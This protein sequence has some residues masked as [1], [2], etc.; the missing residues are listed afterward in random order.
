M[1]TLQKQNLHE[2]L[3]NVFSNSEFVTFLKNNFGINDIP[4]QIENYLNYFDKLTNNG[5]GNVKPI[6]NKT[7]AKMIDHTILKP[8]T[9]EDDV[10]KVCKE[11]KE[12][13]TMSV[14][15][16][17][18]NIELVAN[19]LKNSEVKV[20]TV[21]GFPLGANTTETKVFETEDAIKKGANEI[22]MV[23]NI[24]KL[25]SK[26]YKYVYNDLKAVAD[27]ST[28]N[29]ALS[30]VILETCLL[31]NEEKVIACILSVFAGLNFV[32]TSTGFSTA[33]ANAFDIALM[34]TIV[35]DNIGVKASGG[36]RT[37]KDAETMVAFGANRLG[38]SATVKI[39]NNDESGSQGY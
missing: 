32:K 19:Q 20:C 13:N 9:S 27:V 36:V 12:Y 14:C 29:K 1:E 17:P 7:L 34:R 18:I 11:A 24:G 15:V 28:K 37:R 23:L 21:I 22:D 6:E 10:I 16:N 33:G 4:S 3:K 30:K 26:D 25:K 38:A 5:L 8:E 31:T 2:I 35:G 39:L